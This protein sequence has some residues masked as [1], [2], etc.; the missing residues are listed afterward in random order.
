MNGGG[1]GVAFRE[2]WAAGLSTLSA[3]SA[4]GSAG[5]ARRGRGASAASADTEAP[6]AAPERPAP[7]THSR[8]PVLSSP[9]RTAAPR[10]PPSSP[11]PRR[12][13]PARPAPLSP[14]AAPSRGFSTPGWGV[15][16]ARG[17]GM[18][19]G[20]RRHVPECGPASAGR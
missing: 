10:G 17:Q 13:P 20:E 12:P 5:P 4:R 9:P 6:P 16:P 3:S 15:R 1:G 11:Q 19:G 7:V 8:G 2:S 18:A 14:P